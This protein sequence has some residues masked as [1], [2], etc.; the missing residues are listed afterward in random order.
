MELAKATGGITESSFNALSAFKKAADASENY[1]LLYYAPSDYKRDGKFK[2]IKVKVKGKNYK[3][4]H[5]AG[6]FAN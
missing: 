2:N 4:T 3:V 6:Y 1:Y 5:R